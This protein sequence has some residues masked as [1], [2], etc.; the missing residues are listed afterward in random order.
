[1]MDSYGSERTRWKT[2]IT[3]AM[4]ALIAVGLVVRIVLIW[5]VG[6]APEGGLT[7]GSDAPSYIL[8]AHSLSTGQG[9]AYV[10]QPTALR[11]PLYPLLLSMLD[12]IFG[13][14]A[15]LAMRVLQFVVAILT[16]L[17]CAKTAAI[18]GGKQ[19]QR[20]AFALAL[21]M[22]TLLFFTAQI[23][24]ETF[25]AFLVSIFF[26]FLVRTI[27]E[28]KRV[29]PLVAMGVSAGVLLLLRFNTVFIPLIMICAV[30]SPPV[31][32]RAIKRAAIP[33][34]I[35][36]LFVSPWV[37]RNMIVFHGGILYSS[38][39]GIV[40]F[41]G[42][43][44]PSGRTRPE[45]KGRWLQAGWWLSDIETDSPRRLLF[46]SEVQLN[47]IAKRA[48]WNAWRNL[49]FRVVP[50]L[51]EKASYF[52]LSTDQLFD[53]SGL[54]ASQRFLRACGVLFYW[55]ALAAAIAGCV[56]LRR[57]ERR[58]TNMLLLYCLAATALHL[59]T[60]MN[61]RLRSPLIDPLI[62]ILA[63]LEVSA[64]LREGTPTFERPHTPAYAESAD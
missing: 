5:R 44:A 38:Q 10:G 54:P 1:M 6:K 32:W 58:L 24:T 9:L 34:A 20:I 33:V 23:L 25:A 51:I 27:K 53:T 22:P 62:C 40:A 42:A 26:Y 12:S 8:L 37:I 35:A 48:A 56:R 57:R 59:P 4:C 41:Q 29:L 46:P 61:T 43:V 52:W 64:L 60:T 17:V 11:A 47:R 21:S 31:T 16:A 13:P 15:L 14:N 50:L 55:L 49:G 3:W 7:G 28:E 18:L 36:G 39:T 63:A 45:D 30:L 19:S 2:T